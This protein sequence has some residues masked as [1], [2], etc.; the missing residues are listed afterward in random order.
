MAMRSKKATVLRLY[1][2]ATESLY[3]DWAAQAISQK[4]FT[5]RK[6]SI[7]HDETIHRN[8]QE[9]SGSVAYLYAIDQKGTMWEK[10]GHTGNIR[11]RETNL[12]YVYPGKFTLLHEKYMKHPEAQ[13]ECYKRLRE[14]NKITCTQSPCPTE[15][16]YSDDDPISREKAWE[17]CSRKQDEAEREFSEF[18]QLQKQQKKPE[19]LQGFEFRTK[20]KTS[21]SGIKRL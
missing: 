10:P 7:P 11:Q 2:I 18:Q 4:R 9:Q 15:I 5:E 19:G 20:T 6:E 8:S 1:Y 13:E 21:N 16:F 17:I 14:A 3:R 12:R